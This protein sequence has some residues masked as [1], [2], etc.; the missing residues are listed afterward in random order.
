MVQTLYSI[1]VQRV[2]LRNSRI[3][4]PHVSA[5]LQI[6]CLRNKLG[7]YFH[8]ETERINSDT[9]LTKNTYCMN[10]FPRQHLLFQSDVAQKLL[11]CED[12]C[13]CF[14]KDFVE[15]IVGCIPDFGSFIIELYIPGQK[16]NQLQ[17]QRELYIKKREWWEENADTPGSARFNRLVAE[18]ELTD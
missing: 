12:K 8:Y 13:A 6:C 9:T 7:K 5:T 14:L 15:P 4:N 10:N 11:W 17:N 16:T 18:Y 2:V 3:Q 1:F